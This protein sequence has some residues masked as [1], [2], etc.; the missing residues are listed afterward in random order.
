MAIPV[1]ANGDK[2]FTPCPPG[3]HQAVCVDVVDLGL[4]EVTF[5]GQTKQQHKVAIVWITDEVNPEND[6][7]FLVQQRYTASLNEK[8]NLRRDLQN[9]RGKPF[10]PEELK[11]FDLEKLLGV[12]C[13][14]NIVHKPRTDGSGVWAN[15]G[16]IMPLAR[17]MAKMAIPDDYVRRQDREPQPAT[18]S[19]PQT[20]ALEPDDVVFTSDDDPSFCPF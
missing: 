3:V 6:K 17:G 20:D 4:L 14:L 15:V 9:W 2:T 11:G 16:A 1:S 12:N 18:V 8:S 5:G 13:Q 7:P 19:S 10:T